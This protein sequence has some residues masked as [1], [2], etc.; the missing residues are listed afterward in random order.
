MSVRG[1]VT[2]VI[3]VIAFVVIENL[4]SNVITG[5]D[6]GSTILQ[7]LLLII[8]AAMIMI[9]AVMSIGKNT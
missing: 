5:T 6:T 1:L 9:G 7:N 4:V 3:G 2:V 8:V